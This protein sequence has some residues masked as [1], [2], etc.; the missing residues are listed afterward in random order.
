MNRADIRQA[1]FDQIDWQPESSTD[2]RSKLNRFINRAYQQLA[3]E[4]PI[5]FFEDKAQFRTQIDVS[6]NTAITADGL[7]QVIA[8]INTPGL[9]WSRTYAI[10][11]GAPSGVDA[12]ITEWELDPLGYVT[13]HVAHPWD[14]R[15]LEITDASGRVHRRRIRRLWYTETSQ[16]GAGFHTDYIA[17]DEPLDLE[18]FA[19]IATEYTELDYRISTQSYYLPADTIEVRSL[20][21]WS[22]ERREPLA[23]VYTEEAEQ[24]WWDDIQGSGASGVPRKAFRTDYF[25]LPAPTFRPI[26]EVKKGA[27]SWDDKYK[28]PQGT[29]EFFYTICWGA[30]DKTRV[31]IGETNQV[32]EQR[33]PRWESAPSPTSAQAAITALTNIAEV[34]TP[35]IGAPYGFSPDDG[36]IEDNRSG[37]WKRI[38]ARRVSS[39]RTSASTQALTEDPDEFFL[40]GWQDAQGTI[41]TFNGNLINFTEPYRMTHGYSGLQ[42]SPLP[43]TAYDVDI[44]YLRKPHPL[45]MDQ[46]VPR[47]P[48]EAIEVLVQKAIILV[49]ESLGSHELAA[50]STNTYRERLVTLT[51]RYGSLPSG[52]F[53]KRLAR[54]TGHDRRGHR[55]L[56]E[57]R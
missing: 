1:I 7:T 39:T 53:R 30:I 43:D 54:A 50:I 16:V 55:F 51:K 9:V 41:F 28:Q 49:Y 12:S 5:L 4:A 45:N 33:R 42:L 47:I 3:L 21:I 37:Y 29:F 13:N 20:R 11:D 31:A 46:S 25:Q 32:S 57:E 23:L 8:S 36:E 38:Y 26:V 15:W 52:V 22:T 10:T 14:G 19:S 40:V 6:A 18:E 34:T 27:T 2:A 48:P 24:Q 35:D 44:R 17:L 56:I